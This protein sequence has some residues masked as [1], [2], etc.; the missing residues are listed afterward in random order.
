MVTFERWDGVKDEKLR[1]FTKKVNKGGRQ[2]RGELYKIGGLWPVCQLRPISAVLQEPLNLKPSFS[3]TFADFLRIWKKTTSREE[4]IAK[5]KNAKLRNGNEWPKNL[6]NAELKNS[7]Q[8]IVF[9]NAE[10]KI[11]IHWFFV[12]FENKNC[13]VLC[14]NWKNLH[15]TMLILA[16]TNYIS[17]PEITSDGMEIPQNSYI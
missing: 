3:G 17:Q 7:N 12:K 6:R 15:L 4:K 11:A 5:E 13:E 2:Y 10:L 9:G 14:K 16:C 1:G 8:L